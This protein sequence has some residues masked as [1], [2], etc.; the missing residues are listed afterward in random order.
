MTFWKEGRHG[1]W[2]K[3]CSTLV[4][5]FRE[6][7]VLSRQSARLSLQSS[8][9][10]PPPPPPASECCPLPLFPRV[11]DTLARGRGDGRY[12]FGRMG[13]RSVTL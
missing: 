9:L 5:F 7:A 3:I 4:R 11:G 2:C 12:Q 10:A 8:E 6:A 1:G 13:R